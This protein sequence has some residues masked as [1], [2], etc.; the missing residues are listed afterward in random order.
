MTSFLRRHRVFLAI[1]AAGLVV[2][3][4][5][6]LAY[7]PALWF[8][9]SLG[10][11]AV[12][13]HPYPTVIRPAGYSLLLLWPLHWSHSFL[14]VVI[15]QHL[16][17]LS[18]GVLIY[19]LLVRRGIQRWAAALASATV[20]LSAY[21]I[22]IE[23]FILSDALFIFLLVAA[24]AALLWNPAPG[25]LGCAVAG[26]LLAAA[27][28]TRTEGEVL[29]AALV[30]WLVT[31]PNASWPV[32]TAKAALVCGAFALPLV[33]YAAWFHQNHGQYRL[34]YSTGSFLAARAES[35]ANCPADGIPPADRWL[36][37]TSGHTPDWYL[38]AAAAPLHRVPAG[39]FTK[40][41]DQNGTSFA[42]RVFEA[43]P[44]EYLLTTWRGVL[45]NFSSEGSAYED[46]LGQ[47]S[48][49][50]PARPPIT[51]ARL[52]DANLSR[53]YLAPIYRYDSSPSTQ[54]DQP[55]VSILG[56]YQ[57]VVV[58]PPI[59]AALIALAGLA[60]LVLTQERRGGPGL[61]PWL[62]AAILLIFPAATSGF[63]ARYELAAIAPFCLAAALGLAE[64]TGDAS[65]ARSRHQPPPLA[66]SEPL[67]QRWQEH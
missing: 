22:Q 51:V 40:A 28:V 17:G 5:A 44:M 16:L 43:Q 3:V 33:S 56:V 61:L 29:I 20:L 47:A 24:M 35:F 58:V 8:P 46:G 62:A 30:L 9:D 13:V 26:L 59:A 39:E 45:Q 37:T 48:F 12:G 54:L 55:W 23:H 36:C 14:L 18:A 38:W 52:A 19:A 6:L 42:L 11:A 60:G 63:G 53:G 32:R 10:Y 1:A 66:D 41:S 67:G 57:Q 2:R 25:W 27:A 34:T 31:R 4:I 7:H 49:A 64:I 65:L 15:V 21:E 50:F